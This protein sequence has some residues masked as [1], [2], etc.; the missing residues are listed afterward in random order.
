MRLKKQP[1]LPNE[2]ILLLKYDASITIFPLDNNFWSILGVLKT[3]QVILESTSGV[4]FAWCY[5]W[6]LNTSHINSM[7]RNNNNG[8][9]KKKLF[10][11][12]SSK[13]NILLASLSANEDEKKNRRSLCTTCTCSCLG[14]TSPDPSYCGGA[15]KLLKSGVLAGRG[16]RGWRRWGTG[17]QISFIEGINFTARLPS[18]PPRLGVPGDETLSENAWRNAGAIAFRMK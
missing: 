14:W 5:T 10:L 9:N 8:N 6:K 7:E 3:Q 12:M 1:F 4:N 13:S 16:W 18:V 11:N 15:D 2:F 17:G